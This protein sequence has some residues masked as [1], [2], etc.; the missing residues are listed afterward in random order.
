MPGD[1]RIVLQW[2]PPADDCLLAALATGIN[3]TYDE[4][5]AL[6]DIAL[7]PVTGQPK[8]FEGSGLTMVNIGLR[9]CRLAW[10]PP[11]SCPPPRAG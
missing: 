3:R 11:L 5:A 4:T 6:L 7:D 9:C 10:H 1:P 2:S 8:E